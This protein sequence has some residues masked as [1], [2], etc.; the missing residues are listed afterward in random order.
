MYLVHY[1][2][3]IGT[4]LQQLHHVDY[5]VVLP[6][7]ENQLLVHFVDMLVGSMKIVEVEIVLE[8]FVDFVVSFG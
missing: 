3:I 8:M 1:L 7:F 4:M 2:N 5:L 6:Q